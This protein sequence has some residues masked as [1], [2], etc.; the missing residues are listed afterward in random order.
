MPEPEIFSDHF[1]AFGGKCDVV[2]TRLE[3]S[4]AKRVLQ[5][6]KNEMEQL[7]NIISSASL[8]SDINRLNAD[9]SEEWVAVDSVFIDLLSVC[10][11]FY[12]MSNGAFDVSIGTLEKLWERNNQPGQDQIQS[13]LTNSGFH[14]LEID[15][16][17][18]RVR[19]QKAGVILDF[20]AIDKAYAADVMKNIL[21]ENKITDCIVSFDEEVIL[22]LGVHPS[23]E[24]WP[25]GIRNPL[26]PD[27]FIHEF[28]CTH[29]FVVNTGTWI[30][31]PEKGIP[32]TKK[33]IS[34]ETG[35]LAEGRKMISVSGSS[36]VL[37][38]FLA[39][40]WMILT[41]HDQSIIA[42]QLADMEVFEA[43]FA[44]D[45]VKTKLTVLTEENYE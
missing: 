38:A 8:I 39:H 3:A 24:A 44:D 37:S 10:S 34:P 25:I 43:D 9:K 4:E 2:F 19:F 40:V 1:P 28:E 12:E 18:N 5:M 15:S 41:E 35:R 42:D 32:V 7:E 14:L 11:D 33:V 13:A 36:A 16:E 21:L 17:N 30:L 22:A 45:D 27:E 6:M 23:G 31:D 20:G 26:H 29:R